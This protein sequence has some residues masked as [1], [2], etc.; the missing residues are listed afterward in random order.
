MKTTKMA[1]KKKEFPNVN[2]PTQPTDPRTGEER[3][4]RFVTLIRAEKWWVE[5]ARENPIVFQEYLLDL[6]PA[7]HHKIWTANLFSPDVNRLNIVA[8]RE[9]AK[10]QWLCVIFSWLIGKNSLL[11]NMLLS[12]SAKQAEARL[13]TIRNY[14]ESDIRYRNVFPNVFIDYKR[15]TTQNEFSV[16][17][18][19][20]NISYNVWASIR[21]RH[22]PNDPTFYAA[23]VGGKGVIGRRISG[24]YAGDDLIDE[25]DLTPGAQEK[26]ENYI[27]TTVIPCLQE[28][29]KACNIGTRW[30]QDDVPERFSKN[31]SWKTLTISAIRKNPE[32]GEEE[33]YWPEYW[34]IE[35]LYERK[36]EINNDV[37]WRLMYLSDSQGATAN[38]FTLES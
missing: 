37:I 16:W 9:S 2:P 33:S 29:A 21:Q 35:K 11:T 13:N 6:P 31:T 36:K 7:R 3:K 15:K 25:E 17:S 5:R 23:G 4:K 24:L 10:T 26:R 1:S 28:E 18:N 12:V 38:L 32:T 22:N 20:N 27:L 19:A 34:P 14:I 8:P 30:M